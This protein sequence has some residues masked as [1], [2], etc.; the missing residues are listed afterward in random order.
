MGKKREKVYCCAGLFNFFIYKLFIMMM[1]V[2]LRSAYRQQEFQRKPSFFVYF[3]YSFNVY[4]CR[5][6]NVFPLPLLGLFFCF[7]YLIS[8]DEAG[9]APSDLNVPAGLFLLFCPTWQSTDDKTRQCQFVLGWDVNRNRPHPRFPERITADVRHLHWQPKRL[10]TREKRKT[11]W[12]RRH[13][14]R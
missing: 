13:Q 3:T 6:R 7:Y 5:L 4:L 9:C 1:P 8:S 10:W 11:R 14:C 12:R 2:L